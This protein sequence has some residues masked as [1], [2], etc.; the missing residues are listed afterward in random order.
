LLTQTA[1]LFNFIMKQIIIN[2]K[3]ELL[4]TIHNN[5]LDWTYS[6][7]S[8]TINVNIPYTN[9]IIKVNNE[10]DDDKEFVEYFGLVYDYVN[11]IDLI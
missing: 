5:D 2:C 1:P 11:H 10:I 8:N 9:D 3:P 7:N 6:D 4:E